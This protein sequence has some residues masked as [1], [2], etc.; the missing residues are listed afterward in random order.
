MAKPYE[1]NRIPTLAARKSIEAAV[2]RA[3]SDAG[4]FVPNS[5]EPGECD[6]GWQKLTSKEAT[7]LKKAVKKFG[8]VLRRDSKGLKSTKPR[9]E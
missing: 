4:C 3:A 8:G 1:V 5:G 9:G 7:A 2:G 6:L